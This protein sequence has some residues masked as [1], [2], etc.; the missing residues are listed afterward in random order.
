MAIKA[1]AKD[2][3]IVATRT[4]MA[5]FPGGGADPTTQ[6]FRLSTKGFKELAAISHLGPAL[7]T[8]VNMHRL[9][10]S[11]DQWRKGAERLLEATKKARSAN[12]VEMWR[13]RIDVEAYRGREASPSCRR[14]RIVPRNARLVQPSP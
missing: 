6:S 11:D 10:P 12:S 14:E 13:D 1:A 7:A 3:L 9:D 5:L 8:L 2:P 4:D